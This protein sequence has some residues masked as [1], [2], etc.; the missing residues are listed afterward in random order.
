MKETL[1][2]KNMTDKRYDNS[3]DDKKC[4]NNK[5]KQNKKTISNNPDPQIII[6][7]TLYNIYDTII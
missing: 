7:K 1:T 2:G 5:T 3:N 6:Q 4:G